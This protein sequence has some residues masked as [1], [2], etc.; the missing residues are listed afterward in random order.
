MTGFGP[1][2]PIVPSALTDVLVRLRDEFGEALPPIIIGENGASFP[3]PGGAVFVDDENRISYLAG[4]I[5]AV[6]AALA[7]GVDVEEY[8]VWSLLDNFEWASGY[9]QRFGLV[10][11]DFDTAQRT[12]K[13]SYEW[14][15]ALIAEAR[16]N[17]GLS[18]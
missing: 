8:T 9:T 12:P 11:V 18:E 5:S 10:H 6:G 1:E 14:Y 7:A 3:E 15:R 17:A 13:A 4:H 16:A 2:W